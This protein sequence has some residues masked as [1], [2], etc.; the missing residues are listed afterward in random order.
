MKNIIYGIGTW[1][2]GF[3]YVFDDLKVSYYI[4]DIADEQ[5]QIYP[6]TRVL[7]EKDYR[8]IICGRE[9]LLKE[10]RLQKIGLC[11]QKNYILATDLFSELNGEYFKTK[12]Q[13]PN[14]I[15]VWGTGKLSHQ[16]VRKFPDK[17]IEYWLDSNKSKKGTFYAGSIIRHPDDI[18]DWT[19]KFIIIAVNLSDEIVRYLENRNL[20][21]GKDF[22]TIDQINNI[23][24]ELMRQVMEAV[25]DNYVFCKKP[26]EEAFIEVGGV[27]Y[28]CCP[29]FINNIDIG[30]LKNNRFEDVW[31]SRKAKI[32]RLSILNQSFCFCN[33]DMCI[34]MVKGNNK[35]TYNAMETLKYPKKMM[36]SFDDACNL[37]C[38]S[39]RKEFRFKQETEYARRTSE[40]CVERLSNVMDKV[41]IVSMAGNGDPFFN[42]TYRELWRNESETKRNCIRFQTN[43]LLL[44]ET[45]WEKVLK[46]YKD[47]YLSVSIDAATK[48]TYEKV[49]E[50]GK[51]EVLLNNMELAA[52]M[53]AEK[54]IKNLSICFV[55]QRLNYKE[56][57][58]FINMG[59]Q[60]GVDNIEF[61]R[62]AD[63]DL[64]S[65]EEFLN[66][67]MFDGDNNMLE[68]LKKELEKPIFRDKIVKLNNLM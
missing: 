45:M 25:P 34:H 13:I 4:D 53:R 38:P 3:Q 27:V 50:G 8:V 5:N 6:I 52:K 60:W 56:M 63:W 33:K 41:E 54:K 47:I 66:M 1:Q 46:G 29:Y 67:S 28:L 57:E 18:S 68:E 9:T 62:F 19:G 2:E 44:N 42:A 49:R 35:Q 61:L 14:E 30:S 20:K 55:V 11:Y 22:V 32:I 17:V 59:K 48:E 64:F 23:P 40:L 37:K 26:F 58:S 65:H 24:S 36:I 12:E 16:F 7:E 15:I 43:G 21:Q 31:N 39:C 51:W 10:Q